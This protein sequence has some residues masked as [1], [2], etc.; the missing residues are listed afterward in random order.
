MQQRRPDFPRRHQLIVP[1]EGGLLPTENVEQE[2][3]IGVRVVGIGV[4]E[5]V[6]QVKLG[7]Q[8]GAAEA[9]GFDICF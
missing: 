6:T 7:L 8:R 3:S 5:V 2:A 4:S 1:Y 9:R